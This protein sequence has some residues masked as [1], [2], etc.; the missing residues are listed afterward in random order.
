MPNDKKLAT[1]CGSNKQELVFQGPNL[2]L[3]F[4]AGY[5]VPPFDY[6]GF[7]ANLEFI[8]GQATTV[9]PQT[10]AP[11]RNHSNNHHRHGGGGGGGGSGNNAVIPAAPPSL[12][13]ADWTPAPQKFSPCDKIIIEGL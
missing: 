8:E 6:N 12:T 10:I 5:Q 9:V 2:L 7:A 4:N 3:E 11:T 13:E 1:V